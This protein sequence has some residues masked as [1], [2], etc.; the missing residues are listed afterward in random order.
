MLTI[1]AK[2]AYN[3]KED[4]REN[5]FSWDKENKVWTRE[6]ESEEEYDEFMNHF[7]NVTYYGRA[8]VNKFHSKVVFEKI[9]DEPK[10]SNEPV[11]ASDI[12]AIAEAEG[13]EI[14][15]TTS[16]SNGY[17]RELKYALVGFETYE[18]AERVAKKYGMSIEYFTKHEGWDLYYRTGNKAYS[19]IEVTAED[20]GEDY[21]SFTSSDLEDYYENQVK[22]VISEFEDF[23]TVESFLA[24]QKEIFEEIENLDDGEM[25]LTC[26]GRYYKTV[27]QHTMRCINDTKITVIGL[28]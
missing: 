5:G 27:Q 28:I 14:V 6:F 16:A 10:E 12:Y 2:N 23:A 20:Y 9:C 4:L 1:N 22:G 25:V 26:Q 13:L 21:Q 15:E 24:D 19:A 17:P 11:E 3:S 7:M 18:D 8:V